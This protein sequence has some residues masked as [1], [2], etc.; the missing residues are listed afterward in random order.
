MS[1][2]QTKEDPSV[3]LWKE[4]MTRKEERVESLFSDQ[5]SMHE[6]IPGTEIEAMNPRHSA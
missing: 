1:G 3:K 2:Y 4:S 6:S 5:M